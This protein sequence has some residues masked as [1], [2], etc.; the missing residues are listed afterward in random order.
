MLTPKTEKKILLLTDDQYALGEALQAYPNE[1]R[2]KDGLLTALL[3]DGSTDNYISMSPT[4]VN[5]VCDVLVPW[6]KIS[7]PDQE[8][9]GRN[10]M[11]QELLRQIA[12]RLRE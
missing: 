2:E 4:Q 5:F 3:L 6:A 11:A 10:Q 9:F 1:S 12:L 7:L 8:G